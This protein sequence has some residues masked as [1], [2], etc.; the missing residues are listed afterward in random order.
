PPRRRLGRPAH[1]DRDALRRRH[2]P[3]LG[4]AA[5][6]RQRAL[7]R[8]PRRRRDGGR[9]LAGRLHGLSDCERPGPPARERKAGELVMGFV[10]RHKVLS[11]FAVYIGGVVAIVAATGW[12]RVSNSA[13]QP[14]NEFKL[15]KWIDLGPF[16][17]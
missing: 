2:G 5:G 1:P 11:F 14:Q 13:F 8:R 4:D 16:S 12:H 17:I 3:P 15:D 7:R 6:D 9:V 10:K